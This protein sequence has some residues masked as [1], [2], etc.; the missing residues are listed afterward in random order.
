[1]THKYKA[2]D[3]VLVTSHVPDGRKAPGHGYTFVHSMDAMCGQVYPVDSV[4]SKNVLCIQNWYFHESWVTPSRVGQTI[5]GSELR[6]GDEF[7]L[8]GHNESEYRVTA[9]QWQ[10]NKTRVALDRLH[11]SWNGFLNHR[12]SALI[13]KDGPWDCTAQKAEQA[14][15]KRVLPTINRDQVLQVL[16]DNKACWLDKGLVVTAT[17]IDRLFGTAVNVNAIHISNMANNGAIDV[18]EATW[19]MRRGKLLPEEFMGRRDVESKNFRDDLDA[20]LNPKPKNPRISELKGGQKF[21]SPFG[22]KG[23]K[24]TAGFAGALE[25]RTTSFLKDDFTVDALL[26]DVEVEVLP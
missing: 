2:G 24:I 21:K 3:K 18:T 16:Q 12:I 6:V 15:D 8:P 7:K 22:V 9:L 26:D 23:T 1:M 11:N 17:K 20:W 19:I 4:D 13:T 14:M 25:Y 5:K 10:G